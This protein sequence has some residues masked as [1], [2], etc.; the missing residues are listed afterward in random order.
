M[1]TLVVGATGNVGRE[2]TR[3]LAEQGH[4]VRAVTRDPSKAQLPEGVEVVAGDMMAPVE[5]DRVLEGVDR[6]FLTMPDDNGAAFAE[7]A[8][9]AGL[10]HVVLL[11]SF[12]ASIEL[13]SGEQN[14]VTARHRAGEQALAAA[15]VPTT[16]LR[17]AGFD[18]NILQWTTD[19]ADG[20]V[21]APFVGVGLPKVDP[22]DIA[23]SAVAVL[24][25]DDAKPQTYSITGPEAITM[26]Q[27][28]AVLG[29]LL[30]R[31]LRLEEL[32]A[33][34]AA[35][36]AFPAGTPDFVTT[37][38]LETQGTAAAALVPSGDVAELTGR[39]AR[40][41]RDWATRHLAAFGTEAATAA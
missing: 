1:T 9:R 18:Y 10:Q 21:R 6:A 14:I 27:E 39:P 17:A 19:L 20:V 28:V 33:E 11:S 41:F 40:T 13:P 8:G 25:D 37:S 2:V 30:G 15:G 35:A 32:S 22:D 31:Q 16:A 29:E 24:T 26:R 4:A 7:G 38:V 34:E 5:I 3:L 36:A 23:A 12:A